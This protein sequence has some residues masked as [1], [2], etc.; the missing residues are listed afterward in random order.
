MVEVTAGAPGWLV[1][2]EADYPGWHA[3]LDGHPVPLLTGN[4]LFRTVPI[5]A[6]HHVIIFTYRPASF[7]RGLA[8][9]AFGLAG[10]LIAGITGRR[11][12]RDLSRVIQ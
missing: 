4:H 11:R 9:S 1:L 8:C 7:S 3:A 10:I 12:P 5:P 6:G 2:Q